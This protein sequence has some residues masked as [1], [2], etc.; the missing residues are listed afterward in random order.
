MADEEAAN[1]RRARR[2]F[3]SVVNGRQLH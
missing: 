1:S 3:L 2:G